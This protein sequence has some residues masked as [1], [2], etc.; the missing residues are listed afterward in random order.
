MRGRKPIYWSRLIAVGAMLVSLVARAD[1]AAD[2]VEFF[3]QKIRPVLIESCYKCHSADA[4]KLK[5]G[6]RV[7]TRAALLKGGESGKAS[8]VPGEPEKSY[9]LTAIRYDNPD[10][11]MPPK[12]KL[13]DRQIAD[14]T[15]WIKNGAEDPRTD[16]AAQ[17]PDVATTKEFPK[18]WAFQKFAARS[19]PPV[20]KK[21]WI[22]SPVDRFLLA[23]LE[24]RGL[25][26]APPATRQNLIRRATYDL[27]GLPPTPEEIALF[28][29]DSSPDA[30]AKVVDRLLASPSYGQRWARHWLDVVRYADARDLIQLPAESDFREI[31][32]YRDW[33]V[34][35]FNDDMPYSE[36]TRYQVVGDLLQPTAADKINEDAIVA[37]GFLALADFIPGDNDKDMMIADYVNDQVDVTGRTF[38]GLTLG[39]ARC[40]DHKFD[41]ISIED[42]YALAGIF[43]STRLIPSPVP[44]NTPLVRVPLASKCEL[45]RIEAHKKE[46]Q[47]LEGEIPELN[48]QLRFEYLDHL[49]ARAARQAADYLRA[50][51]EH[52]KAKRA[53]R[54]MTTTQLAQKYSLDG[55]ILGQWLELLFPAES[56]T[57][58]AS[59][60]AWGQKLFGTATDRP[61]EKVVED[62][63]RELGQKFSALVEQRRTAEESLTP[64]EKNLAKAEL[65]KLQADDPNLAV[66]KDE[67]VSLWPSRSRRNR[68]FLSAVSGAPG[69]IRTNDT[70]RGSHRPVI[71]FGGKSLLQAPIFAPP[72]G[73]VCM[74]V[75]LAG[76][77][78]NQRIIGWEDSDAGKH[79][80]GVLTTG[81]GGLHALFRK[82]GAS[83]DIVAA[84]RTNV[85]YEMITLSWGPKGN[86]LRRDG[87]VA[88]QNEGTKGVS[89]DPEIKA[90][91]LGGPGSGGAARF[92][93]AIA[94]FRVYDRQLEPAQLA[95][96][97]NE[98]SN[99]WFG[100]EIKVE[101]AS[102]NSEVERQY[103][104]ISSAKGPFRLT[105]HERDEK[106]D[107]NHLLALLAKEAALQEKKKVATRAVPQAVAVQEGGPA[108]TPYEGFKDSPIF[109]RGNPKTPG[110]VARRGIPKIFAAEHPQKI[111][112]GSGRLELA[113]WLTSPENPLP[114][115]VMV[116][117]IWQYHFGDGLVRTSG[118][119]GLRGE[120]PSN[121]ELLDY[122]AQEFIRSGWSLKAMHR[123]IMAS[124]AYQQSAAAAPATAAAD[125]ENRLF[126]RMNDRRLDAEEIRDALLSVAGNL[127]RTVSGPGFLEIATPRRSLYLMTVRTGGSS[128]SFGSL[129]D[130]P[131]GGRVVEKRTVSTVAPQALFWMNDPFVLQQ[132]KSLA[133]RLDSDP[134]SKTIHG[135]IMRAYRLLY[136][137][138]PDAREVAVG[139]RFLADS[140]MEQLEAYCQILFCA[141]EFIEVN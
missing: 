27:N 10:V 80:V 2:K 1:S 7:D 99:K 68:Q 129:F 50:A 139:A 66:E 6:L 55:S 18:H 33:V 122:L 20:Q 30:F 67:R 137:R 105:K 89:S 15:E 61:D 29:A 107:S 28:E 127:D 124:S 101:L 77:D 51:W 83:G 63:I 134:G 112:G 38:L 14:F 81:A 23:A 12:K 59:L 79:G 130:Q 98:I 13:S 11:Q 46:V 90:L 57:N 16:S 117:R 47:D 85:G 37:T 128:T 108:K 84:G 94:E 97:E 69:P 118:N 121:P 65:I 42:Y 106:F 49:E 32:R 103:N 53:G 87:E 26:A 95:K 135:K 4:E 25:P 70:V 78:A 116:N 111:D 41:P 58:Q 102:G 86:L 31:W 125:P 60:A 93:G 131:D 76:A 36:F 140:R 91:K 138:L 48:R 64:E 132:A 119:F 3:E 44:G 126:G 52:Q 114:A 71:R 40:H 22:K 136:G 24:K 73:T 21:S 9:L 109:N 110:K 88:G 35:A 100:A 113:E 62:S 120:P 115:R 74:V 82:D 45:D 5:G 104:E 141:N 19:L 54:E 96:V 75:N 92:T 123:L 17:T 133:R 56:S 43:F 72:E 34:K 39:C 8:I